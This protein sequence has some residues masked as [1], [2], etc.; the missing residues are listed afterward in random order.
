MQ[1]INKPNTEFTNDF[2]KEIYEQTYKYGNEDINGTHLRIAQDVAKLEEDPILRTNEF[3]GVL[4]QFRFTPGG[5]IISN[6]GT[7]IKGTTYINCFVAGFMGED[8]DSMLGIMN[9]LKD[10]ALILKSEG[11]YGFC[12]DVMR[13]RGAFIDGIANDS[14]GAVRLLDMWDT[15][16]AVITEGSGLKSDNDK[17][18][19]KIRKGAQMVTLSCFSSSTEVLTNYGWMNIVTLINK[20]YGGDEIYAIIKNGES[21]LI[22]NPIVRPP[23]PIFEIETVDG[24]KIRVTA[25]HKFEVKNITTGEIYLKKISEIDINVEEVCI[26]EV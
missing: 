1:E 26:I 21:K 6:A 20:V 13:P 3:L 19:V 2:S 23:E 16:S 5:R 15:Q 12:A 11:G 18:K 14:P 25:D 10:Q 17:K 24:E 4:E 8:Q 22:S 7:G 9:A